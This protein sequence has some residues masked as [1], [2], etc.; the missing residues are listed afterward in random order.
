MAR[1]TIHAV[2]IAISPII[3]PGSVMLHVLLCGPLLLLKDTFGGL[4]NRD[5]LGT[6]AGQGAVVAPESEFATLILPIGELDHQIKS[7]VHKRLHEQSASSPLRHR[8]STGP[9]DVFLAIA[10]YE[11]TRDNAYHFP[12]DI[13]AAPGSPR[14]HQ[15]PLTA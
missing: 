4:S 8:A 2:L 9:P 10:L 12:G 7:F 14:N 6:E 5:S 13:Y 15:Y 3:R 11:P 1:P